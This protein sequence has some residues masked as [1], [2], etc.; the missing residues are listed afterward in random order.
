VLLTAGALVLAA[1]CKDHPYPLKFNN[2]IARANKKLSAAGK[3]LAAAVKPLE[4]GQAVDAQQVRGSYQ[5]MTTALKDVQD[6][7]ADVGAPIGTMYGS[8][9][10]DAFTNFLDCQQ[11]ILNNQASQIVKIAED[12]TLDPAAKWERISAQLAKIGEEE[13]PKFEALQ[14]AQKKYAEDLKLKLEK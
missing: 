6:E 12:V 10:M 8:D 14:E 13:K 4:S 7:F 2:M 3:D 9:L 11:T 1:G 5:K